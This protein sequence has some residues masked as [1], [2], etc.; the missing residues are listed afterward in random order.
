M[1]SHSK[2]ISN[3]FLPPLHGFTQKQPWHSILATVLWKYI[4]IISRTLSLPPFYEFIL[5]TFLICFKNALLVVIIFEIV[6]QVKYNKFKKNVLLVVIIFEIV[7]IRYKI[8]LFF[9][10]K[11][12]NVLLVFII[13]IF[14]I[15]EIRYKVV[16]FFPIKSEVY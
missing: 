13:L 4:S 14:E 15:V 5:V 8:V 16:L 3:L 11:S 12:E 2:N 10:I 9:P 7:E 1:E 6:D